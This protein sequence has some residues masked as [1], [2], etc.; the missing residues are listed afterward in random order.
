MPL[1]EWIKG[2]LNLGGGANY[3]GVSSS[4][5]NKPSE[6]SYA[7]LDQN[8]DFP[9][10]VIS[11]NHKPVKTNNLF[12]D[13]HTTYY[14]MEELY[15]GNSDI[16][17]AIDTV[18]NMVFRLGFIFRSSEKDA[19]DF[20]DKWAKDTDFYDKLEILIRN[21]LLY[22]NGYAQIVK[23]PDEKY[24]NINVLHPYY[25]KAVT[26]DYGRVKYWLYNDK[27]KIQPENMLVFRDSIIGVSPYGLPPALQIETV[28]D[29]KD[30]LQNV[31]YVMAFYTSVGFNVATVNTDGLS[32]VKDETTGK[33]KKDIYLDAVNKALNSI[34]KI[35][36]NNTV[37]LVSGLTVEDRV[38][39][40]SLRAKSDFK[41]LQE[42]INEHKKAIYSRFHVP[43]VLVSQN[44]SSNR[45]TSYNEMVAFLAYIKRLWNDTVTE[46]YKVTDKLGLKGKFDFEEILKDDIIAATVAA[47]RVADIGNRGWLESDEVREIISDFLGYDID[48]S[49]EVNPIKYTQSGR[50]GQNETHDPPGSDQPSEYSKD[51]ELVAFEYVIDEEV[52]NNE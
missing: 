24:I 7:F 1:R 41:G 12:F 2:L 32:T 40:D 27:D 14:A 13:P 26:D 29:R 15:L 16:A 25:V 39:I 51:D 34:V 33:S 49:R 35:R 18:V 5:D 44:D 9:S 23:F 45:A 10:T 8:R 4:D 6:E 19:E 50:T 31:A 28:I 38:K 30:K 21:R 52:D 47:W 42:V 43:L 22:G 17:T 11:G 20:W 48:P 46:L 37:E 3:S 36:D